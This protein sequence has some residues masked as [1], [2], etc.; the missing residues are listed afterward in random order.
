MSPKARGRPLK[1]G[2]PARLLALTLPDDVVKGLRRIHPDPGWAIV[3]LYEKA[4]RKVVTASG[5]ELLCTY[6]F[7]AELLS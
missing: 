6:P 3:S 2:R 7:D 4:A 5:A 1:F